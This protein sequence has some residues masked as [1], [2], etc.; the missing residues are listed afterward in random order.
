MIEGYLIIE[1]VVIFQRS[2]CFSFMYFFGNLNYDFA[3]KV[4]LVLVIH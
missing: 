3:G 1:L 4:K 2:L